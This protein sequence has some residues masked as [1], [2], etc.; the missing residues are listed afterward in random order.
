[1]FEKELILIDLQ[2]QLSSTEDEKVRMVLNEI[3][4]NISNN[5]YAVRTWWQHEKENSL[6]N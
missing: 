2:E 4:F 3:I 1:M 5:K 6:R